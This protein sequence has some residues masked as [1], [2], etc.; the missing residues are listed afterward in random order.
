MLGGV[1]LRDLG[2]DP[3]LKRTNELVL[4][5]G[6]GNWRRGHEGH[7][8]GISKGDGDGQR[9]VHSFGLS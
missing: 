1:G 9:L 5:L 8:Q 2:W 4:V 7:E 6:I 3:V